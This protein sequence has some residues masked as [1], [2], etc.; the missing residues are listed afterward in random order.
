MSPKEMKAREK[1]QKK[2]KKAQ[3]KALKQR[4]KIQKQRQKLAGQK[5]T[6]PA[7]KGGKHEMEMFIEKNFNNPS[8]RKNI[9]GNVVVACVVDQ[10]GK[11]VE[12]QVV[13]SV[14]EDLNK[15]AL[16]VAKEMR[17]KPATVGKRKVK[18]RIDVVF[19]IRHGRLSFLEL[20]T[21]EV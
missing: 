16:R 1:A 14:N 12:A 20:Q 13:R 8:E 3:E 7:Y 4:Q 15:E 21:I 19:P 17:F 5:R 9:E 6:P 18:G 2:Q 11:V 10:K